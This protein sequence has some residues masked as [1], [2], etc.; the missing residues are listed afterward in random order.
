MAWRFNGTEAVYVQIADIIRKDIIGG[1]YPSGSQL[2]TV[3]QLAF[4][5]SVNPN[6][7]QRALLLLEEE[8]LLYSRG[9]VGRFVTED[10]E[11][12][13][14]AR[15][16]MIRASI[17]ALVDGARELGLSSEELVQYI[18]DKEREEK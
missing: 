12:L 16:R 3:R 9:T 15:Q 11:A 18:N 5:A 17:D 10:T 14:G 1:K 6:T 7:M 4:E 13:I 2:P 8:G